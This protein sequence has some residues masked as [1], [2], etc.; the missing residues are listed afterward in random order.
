MQS[1]WWFPFRISSCIGNA[2]GTP[3]AI[4]SSESYVLS[5]QLMA[6]RQVR[7]TSWPGSLKACEVQPAL[8]FC[9]SAKLSVCVSHD[10][11][12]WV[13]FNVVCQVTR[14]EKE[15]LIVLSPLQ[16]VPLPPGTLQRV[17]P[18]SRV[19]V[20]LLLRHGGDWDRGDH[21]WIWRTE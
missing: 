18:C 1:Q 12:F 4:S 8:A 6:R 21:T 20:P 10:L 2:R 19:P 13:L 5:V 11:C 9:H 16:Y 17:C 14:K 7:V 15:G 3:S